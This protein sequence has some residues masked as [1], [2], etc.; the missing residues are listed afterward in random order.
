MRIISRRLYIL[1]AF[2]CTDLFWLHV[3]ISRLFLS[4]SRHQ[5]VILLY[6]WS[7]TWPF[8]P[9]PVLPK[10]VE[11]YPGTALSV[12][13]LVHLSACPGGLDVWRLQYILFLYNTG[14]T[15]LFYVSGESKGPHVHV[16]D[17]VS[18][19][20]QSLP[21]RPTKKLSQQEGKDTYAN[22]NRFN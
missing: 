15:V 20:T 1:R 10:R 3:H 18:S 16:H 5:A 14:F 22:V 11:I 2:G 9:P 4:P 17:H 6:T 19:Y 12:S 8:C 21:D 13:L 7:E